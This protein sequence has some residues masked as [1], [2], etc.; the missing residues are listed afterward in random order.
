M[1]S[2]MCNLGLSIQ[3]L[4]DMKEPSKI[5]KFLNAT[6]ASAFQDPGISLISECPRD[7]IGVQIVLS[8]V[9]QV[10]AWTHSH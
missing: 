6:I 10:V 1:F 7:R 5:F 9:P 8:K 3:D 4:K 2:A